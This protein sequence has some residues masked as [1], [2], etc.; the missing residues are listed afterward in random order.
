MISAYY[1]ASLAEIFIIDNTDERKN[2]MKKLKMKRF[3]GLV[4][5]FAL[6]LTSVP[7][8]G[9][10]E[11]GETEESAAA[12]KEEDV[13]NEPVVLS[14]DGIVASGT[15]GSDAYWTLYDSGLIEISGSGYMDGYSN[16]DYYYYGNVLPW[17][18]YRENIKEV[19][20]S[21]EI[22][23]VGNFSFDNC[24]NLRDVKL[25][26][27][28]I[29]ID[30]YAFSRTGITDSP[31]T[32]NIQSVGECAFLL[33]GLLDNVSISKNL[34]SIGEGAFSGCSKLSKIIVDK[35][36]TKYLS[37]NGVLYSKDGTSIV[38]YP[39]NL[40]DTY[41][42]LEN[43]TSIAKLAF[44]YCYNLKEIQMPDSIVTINEGAFINC[45]SISKIVIPENVTTIG[46]YAFCRCYNLEEIYFKGDLPSIN[47][48]TFEN[49]TA[50]IYY[51]VNNNTWTEDSLQN[52]GGTIT[53]KKWNP[54]TG[55]IIDDSQNIEDSDE[56]DGFSITSGLGYG[57]YCIIGNEI[58]LMGSYTASNGNAEEEA[59]AI[60]WSSSNSDIAEIIE[61]SCD[62]GSEKVSYDLTVK[63]HKAGIATITGV[64]EDGRSV[65][66][67]IS[68]E[69]E[70]KFTN[71]KYTITETTDIL[72][73]IEIE[74]SDYEYLSQF[75]S[76]ISF[77]C[78][79]NDAYIA[80]NIVG[81][82]F[83]VSENGFFANAIVSIDP[84]YEGSVLLTATSK[85]GQETECTVY[86]DNGVLPPGSVGYIW[87][88]QKDSWG[89]LNSSDAFG[90]ESDGY[91]ISDADYTRLISSLSNTD[92]ADITYNDYSDD[93]NMPVYRLHIGNSG[94]SFKNWSGSCYGM[95][96]WACLV[97]SGDLSIDSLGQDCD[98]LKSV[99]M[100]DIVESAINYY[101]VQQYLYNLRIRKAE[102]L[103]LA[104]ISQLER[105]E[106]L[107]SNKGEVPI[108][109][110]YQWY[111]HF[112]EDGKCDK[113]SGIAHA[114]VGYDIEYGSWDKTVNG[115]SE[116]YSKRILIYDC[117]AIPGKEEEYHLYFNN[118]GVWCIPGHN[119]ISFSSQN[120]D[121]KHN[122]GQLTMATTDKSFI[123]AIDKS[124]KPSNIVTGENSSVLSTNNAAFTIG[125]NGNDCM[126][127]GFTV[128]SAVDDVY[129]YVDA[130][131]TAEGDIVESNVNVILPNT[132]DGYSV[133]SENEPLKFSLDNGQ[134]YKTIMSDGSGTV[135]FQANGDLSVKTDTVS[136]IK[137][138]ITANE[139]YYSLPWHT[140]NISGQDM[141]NI[142]V[143]MENSGILVEG[144]NLENL[145]ITV[146]NNSECFNATIV[147]NKDSVLISEND[148]EIAV[149][150]D[151]DDDGSYDKDITKE[152]TSEKIDL[153][154]CKI[155]LSESECTY[156][157]TEKEPTVMITNGDQ[158]L[159]EGTDYTIV[160]SNNVNAGTASVTA[161]GQGDYTGT[162]TETFTIKKADQEIKA[163]ISS[164]NLTEGE[165][166]A[167]DASAVA[168]T[169]SYSSSDTAVAT[170]DENGVVTAVSI[171]TAT[172]TITAEGNENYNS[173]TTAIEITV[174]EKP[175][176]HTHEYG[177]PVFEWA[178]DYSCKAVFTCKD[179]DDEQ[180]LDCTV[181]SEVTDPTCT[182]DGETVY[183]ATVE[184][185]GQ[186]YTDTKT[187]PGDP[188]TGHSYEYT[189]NGD[190]THT[191]TCVKEDDSFTEDHIFKDGVCICGAKEESESSEPSKPA[192]TVKPWWKA[193]LEKWFG[194][195]EDQKP[196]FNIWDWLFGWWW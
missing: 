107:A 16:E 8:T 186:T 191:A 33:C 122:N 104:Q 42:I 84:I 192:E 176:Q 39:A 54:E 27:N 141:S 163:T 65:S 174:T 60:E 78:K 41:A 158:A 138:Q 139:G 169:L 115:V 193:W 182:K 109:I 1:R 151:S 92:I 87:D 166:A 66:F 164:A 94:G 149:L 114:V 129:A 110:E 38:T 6:V 67:E 71:S 10:A 24:P 116:N 97:K 99:Q 102:F 140:A 177:D 21:G 18:D 91:Y 5:A 35:K 51:P 128:D 20:I 77:K 113:K 53:W 58:K 137:V 185:D 131:L 183:T 154:T 157:G 3:W 168:G 170:V 105:L 194:D 73:D 14:E 106:N 57:R 100:T 195:V 74:D 135:F 64:A 30:N 26:D 85:A 96:A 156:D 72:V 23:N 148:G 142:S 81:T 22:K 196:G 125:I 80:A 190:G 153:S 119:I 159:I 133:S 118:D 146:R 173:A 43:T 155:A 117:S 46:Q 40:S 52:Y 121:E 184:F 171:G 188:A 36:N 25:G 11:T 136:D 37:Q 150:E 172:I 2:E 45:E 152:E 167:I 79:E 145:S 108:F 76:E 143:S 111:S 32:E 49:V 181:T 68:V 13:E 17:K 12:S 29:R 28:V 7:L 175:Q 15:C 130:N 86:V 126:V 101:H 120:R 69:P 162:I 47:T 187:V 63:G 98:S 112:F 90:P 144:D 180:T 61:F 103:S 48:K 56:T 95:S 189:D 59:N 50:N 88:S 34:T 82:D 161:T 134:Y 55:E 127:E 9:L 93:G 19:V 83:R 75:A 147:S 31:L 165:T 179:K 123:N 132:D 178:E 70:L 124:G 89:F 62:S 160:Y 44:G 4:L